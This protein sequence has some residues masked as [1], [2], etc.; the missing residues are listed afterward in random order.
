MGKINNRFSKSIQLAGIFFIVISTTL[1]CIDNN[2][3]DSTINTNYTEGLNHFDEVFVD[4]F[5]SK[6]NQKP[7]F[8]N[9]FTDTKLDSYRIVL[10]QK[11]K[12]KDI[13]TI[14]DTLQT[15]VLAV[16]NANDTCNLVVNQF[17]NKNNWFDQNKAPSGYRQRLERECLNSKYP[18]PNFWRN[19]LATDSNDCR[20]PN[21][22]KIYVI[23]AQQGKS[24]NKKYLTS[25]RYMPEPWKNGYSKGIA[26]SLDRNIIIY[27]FVIW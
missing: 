4:H 6:L 21:D 2:K 25:G 19:K 7:I 24:L 23:Q 9:F 1:S 3:R 5:P 12:E 13:E 11:M 18:I 15:S 14:L 22:F 8:F 16:Y 17:T 20:L 27:W 10:F 26:A